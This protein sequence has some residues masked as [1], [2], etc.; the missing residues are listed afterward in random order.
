MLV[1]DG[2]S[3]MKMMMLLTTFIVMMLSHQKWLL[4][5]NNNIQKTATFH[6]V[7]ITVNH[8]YMDLVMKH[9]YFK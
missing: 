4:M 9:G 7:T 8:F 5:N 3:G 6:F 2:E 1:I